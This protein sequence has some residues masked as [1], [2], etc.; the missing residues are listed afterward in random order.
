MMEKLTKDELKILAA[1]L[2]KAQV[3]VESAAMAL[4]LLGKLNRIIEAMKDE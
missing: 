1:L 3:A 2:S 4:E